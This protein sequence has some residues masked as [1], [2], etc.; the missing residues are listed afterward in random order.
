MLKNRHLYSAYPSPY[1]AYPLILPIPFLSVPIPLILLTPFVITVYILGVCQDN[2]R[3]LSRLSYYLCLKQS[4][5]SKAVPEASR[6][7]TPSSWFSQLLSGEVLSVKSVVCVLCS[8]FFVLTC[9]VLDGGSPIQI[10]V[11]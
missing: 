8:L 6:L 3:G 2:S 7:A 11:Q 1:C 10:L 5:Q 4:L 9:C